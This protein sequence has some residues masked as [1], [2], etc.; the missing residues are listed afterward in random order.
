MSRTM[1]HLPSVL[2]VRTSRIRCTKKLNTNK[3]KHR[4]QGKISLWIE[5]R[6]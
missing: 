2:T 4:I 1:N 5:N 3:P 6:P